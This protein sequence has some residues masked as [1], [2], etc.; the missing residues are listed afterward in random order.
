M[1]SKFSFLILLIAIMLTVIGCSS[2]EKAN[3]KTES[4]GENGNSDSSEIKEKLVFAPNTDAQSLDPH[5]AND[6]TSHQIVDMIYN[7]LINYD[8]DNNIVGELAEEWEVDEAGTTWTFKLKEGIKFHDGEDFNARA[9]KT[10]FDRL[11]NLDNGLVHSADYQF[12]TDVEV[13]DD[14]TVAFITKEPYGLFEEL[15]TV[16]ATAIISPKAIEEY[17]NDV[18]KTLES[19]I[20]TG[21]YKITEWKKDQILTLER[22]DDYFGT[23][24]VTKIIEYRTIPEDATRVMALEAG[25]VDV[26]QQIPAQDL[27]RLENV[28]GIEVVKEPS[29]GQRQFRFDVSKKPLSDVKVRQAISYAIDR[30]TII[31]KVVPGIGYLPTSAMPPVMPDYIDLG[32]IPYDP[33][34]SKQLLTEA[35]YPDGFKTKITT[36]SR[37][38]QGV[39]LA[40]V[41]SDQLRQVGIEAEINV[42]EWGDIVDEWSGL[43]ADE[44]DQGI[45]IM[46]TGG[47]NS[48]RQLR[49]I[50][51]TA[52][53]NERNYGFYSN[54]EFDKI[55]M[56]ALTE[57]D[58]EKRR[59]LYQRA[60]EIVYKE[61]PAAFW[62]HDQYSMVAQRDNVKNVDISKFSLITFKEAYVEK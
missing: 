23:K 42:M 38:L 3:G 6:H 28:D 9:V 7:R 54:A 12:I 19:S 27:A 51:Y 30:A 62:L 56:E 25:E 33:E 17:G 39:E 8:K 45:F 2:G 57:L 32:E 52:E 59:K 58:A 50:Y 41:I 11:L 4:N 18:G 15:M 60:Q 46:G 16:L 14:F 26:I 36:T 37:Y 1:K 40:E 35:G 44:F 5:F 61:D 49:P 47:T 24:G 21:P 22:N 43:T 20:G 34:K 31:E 13:I 29:I 48:D 55:I 10:S 53:T